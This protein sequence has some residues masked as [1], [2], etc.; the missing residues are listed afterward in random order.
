MTITGRKTTSRRNNRSPATT[1][2]ATPLSLKEGI[3]RFSQQKVT[4]ADLS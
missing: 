1:S 2:K 4:F 3:R